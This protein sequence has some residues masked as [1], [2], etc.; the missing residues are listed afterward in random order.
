MINSLIENLLE[1]ERT[2]RV[3]ADR[4]KRK[5][6]RKDYRNGCYPRSLLTKFGDIANIQVPRI[7]GSHT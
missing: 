6:G 7:S 4:N 5:K 2:E 1:D 3:G